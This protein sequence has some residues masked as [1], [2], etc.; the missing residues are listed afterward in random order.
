MIRRRGG[1]GFGEACHGFTAKHTS[2][3]PTMFP[4]QQFRVMNRIL[5]LVASCFSLTAH[6]CACPKFPVPSENHAGS[7]QGGTTML[8]L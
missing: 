6:H 3:S 4:T 1:G 5:G 8:A 7:G 2:T